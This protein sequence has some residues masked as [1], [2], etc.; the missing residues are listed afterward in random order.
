MK[1]WRIWLPV[2]FLVMSAPKD[3][4]AELYQWNERRK[5]K[6]EILAGGDWF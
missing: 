2:S 4:V 6:E 3:L 5:R 1:S